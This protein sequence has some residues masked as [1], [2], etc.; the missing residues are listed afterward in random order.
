M[1]N[2]HKNDTTWKTLS[3]VIPNVGHNENRDEHQRFSKYT[4]LLY[5][6]YNYSKY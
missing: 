1:L 4:V 3:W 2:I 5:N 6:T